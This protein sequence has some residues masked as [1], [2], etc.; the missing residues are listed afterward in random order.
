ML[1]DS[2]ASVAEILAAPA[3]EDLVVV[4]A[5]VIVAADGTARLCDALRESLPP[6]C[7]GASMALEN[8]P[9][10]FLTGLQRG[11]GG[12][13]GPSSRPS[14]RPRSGASVFV[15]DPEALVAS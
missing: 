8:L 11:P 5:H 1:A 10:G 14:R 13:T 4:R 15:N 3:S 12:S 2:G 6:Q 9:Q 7:G